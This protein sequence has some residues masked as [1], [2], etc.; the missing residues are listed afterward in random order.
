VARRPTIFGE[1]PGSYETFQAQLMQTFAPMDGYEYALAAELVDITWEIIQARHIKTTQLRVTL[2]EKLYNVLLGLSQTE[3]DL[4][5]DA[6]WDAHVAA[7]GTED[8]WEPAV[9]YDRSTWSEQAEDLAERAT[10]LDR[11]TATQAHA[12]LM[13][14]GIEQSLILH[15]AYVDPMTRNRL[16]R[17]EDRQRILERRRRELERDY[18]R[19]QDRRPIEG[20]ATEL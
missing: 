13:A 5:S 4:R 14:L 19:V 11:V 7:G 9:K 8:N 15:E 2:R 10:R 12:E 16:D 18:R 3:Y 17:L 20:E 1:D 6:D